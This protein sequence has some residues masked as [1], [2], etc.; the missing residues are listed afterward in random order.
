MEKPLPLRRLDI[1]REGVH[2]SQHSEGG[3]GGGEIGRDGYGCK[4][5]REREGGRE[6]GRVEGRGG[7]EGGRGR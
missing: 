7:K 5:E 2:L 6:G 4:D 3:E 1:F